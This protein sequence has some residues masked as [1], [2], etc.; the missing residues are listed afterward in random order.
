M[1]VLRHG[2]TLP[3]S[4]ARERGGEAVI[5][6]LVLVACHRCKRVVVGVVRTPR[7]IYDENYAEHLRIAPLRDV[8]CRPYLGLPELWFVGAGSAVCEAC[9]AA[10]PAPAKE[11]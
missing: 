8:T 2:L 5:E 11:Q 1:L 3:R 7:G 10:R 9:N 4:A 6:S